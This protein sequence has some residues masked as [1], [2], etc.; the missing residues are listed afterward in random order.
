MNQ[1]PSRVTNLIAQ[2]R[3]TMRRPRINRHIRKN[4]RPGDETRLSRDQQ[5]RCLADES[6]HHKRN[7][8]GGTG[9]EKGAED[10]AE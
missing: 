5:E 6:D 10:A 1:I 7:R 8:N 9:A 2:K 3:E 4:T